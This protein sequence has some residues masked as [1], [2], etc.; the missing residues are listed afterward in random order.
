MMLRKIRL[1]VVFK[2]YQAIDL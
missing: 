1:L 2:D